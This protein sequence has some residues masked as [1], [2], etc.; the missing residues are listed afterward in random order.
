MSKM[1]E[2]YRFPPIQ[3]VESGRPEEGIV[4]RTN[5]QVSIPG[6]IQSAHRVGYLVD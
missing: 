5:S 1:P 3:S 4:H 6:P 2:K